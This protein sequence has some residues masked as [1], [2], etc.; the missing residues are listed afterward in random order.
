MVAIRVSVGEYL[1]LSMFLFLGCSLCGALCGP[2][3]LWSAGWMAMA[4]LPVVR[5][6]SAPDGVNV[7]S[8]V[9]GGSGLVA[10]VSGRGGQ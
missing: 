3:S 1:A 7:S 5:G 6:C 9:G 2:G 10:W 4:L 8:I